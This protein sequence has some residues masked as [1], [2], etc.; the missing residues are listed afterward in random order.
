MR[1]L[2]Y[3]ALAL[4]LL[5]PAAGALEDGPPAGTGTRTAT[6]S[7]YC[8]WT[9]EATLGRVDGVLA[10]RIGHWGG[11]EVV[12][13]DY[14]PEKTDLAELVGALKD[15]RSFDS[16]V[17]GD[18]AGKLEVTRSVGADELVQHSGRPHFIEPKHTLRQRHP[19]LY[20]LGLTEP[21]AIQLNAWSYFGG[22]MPDVLTPEQK[23]KLASR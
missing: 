6:F 10:S 5:S 15:R 18:A 14:D 13:V 11:S 23:K 21:Q 20:A 16:V 3:G 8:Y 2:L 12:Q 1:R 4:L 22:V 7:M 9:G 17:V 19:E